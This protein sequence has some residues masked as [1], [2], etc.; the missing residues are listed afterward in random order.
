MAC[1]YILYG[2]LIVYA[3]NFEESNGRDFEV[4]TEIC[5]LSAH[6]SLLN[7]ECNIMGCIGAVPFAKPSSLAQ[8]CHHAASFPAGGPGNCKALGPCVL[9]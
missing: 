9:L 1:L 8:Q 3:R 5:H 4:M 6:A 2:T 7:E